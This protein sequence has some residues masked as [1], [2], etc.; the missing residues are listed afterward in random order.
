M[1]AAGEHAIRLSISPPEKTFVRGSISVSPDGRRVALRGNTEGKVLLW[2]VK[3][4]AIAEILAGNSV[5][6]VAAR[7]NLPRKSVSNWKASLTPEQLAE[8]S[9]NTGGRL[10]EL[11]CNHVATVLESLSAQARAAGDREYLRKQSA[12]DLARLHGSMFEQAFSMLGKF[13]P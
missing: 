4:R 1:P 8:V 2:V 11:V 5:T 9:R 7:H 13:R 6:V 3:A 12:G 10:D